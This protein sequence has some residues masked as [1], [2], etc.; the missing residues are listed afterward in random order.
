MD[1]AE[2]RHVPLGRRWLLRRGLQLAK[3]ASGSSNGVSRKVSPPAGSCL[4]CA[5]DG[6]GPESFL[7]HRAASGFI[8][9][10]LIRQPWTHKHPSS[11]GL[12]CLAKPRR[13]NDIQPLQAPRPG[14]LT[15]SYNVPPACLSHRAA[16]WLGRRNSCSSSGFPVQHSWNPALLPDKPSG[17]LTDR[18]QPVL[19][20]IRSKRRMKATWNQAVTFGVEVFP[21]KPGS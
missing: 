4:R 19:T 12:S 21:S 11:P 20:R 6:Y 1:I 9:Q 16:L 18:D 10:G 3:E 7:L 5:G 14:I 17:C 2:G 13:S 15:A 8:R